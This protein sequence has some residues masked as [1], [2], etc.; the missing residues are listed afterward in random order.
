MRNRVVVLVL[1]IG[2]TFGVDL[3][4]WLKTLNWTEW[5]YKELSFFAAALVAT[6]AVQ[7]QS[8]RSGASVLKDA[9]R[10]RLDPTNPAHLHGREDDVRKFT[11]ALDRG[12]V[13]LVGESG[14][15]KSVTA[16]SIMRLIPDPP[17]KTVGGQVLFEGKDLLKLS[18]EE[19]RSIRGNKISM[20]FQEPGTSLNPVFT[21][22]EQI[23]ESI[24]LHQGKSPS[25]AKAEA[26]RHLDR[27]GPRPPRRVSGWKK[28][29]RR[30][31]GLPRAW[32]ARPTSSGWGASGSSRWG[33]RSA[34][35]SMRPAAG[36]PAPC[37]GARRG[38]TTPAS[39]GSSARDRAG[40][41]CRPPAAGRRRRRAVVACKACDGR[42]RHGRRRDG[43]ER[44]ER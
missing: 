17:G 4:G 41:A 37:P 2:T 39:H 25:E 36:R 8:S 3:A 42:R 27:G 34:R 14:S 18:E 22:G 33:C 29:R 5:T 20:I 15:G 40:T 23:A 26:L 38:T 31:R 16:L 43:A 32:R 44:A 28:S 19:M 1:A 30:P 13:F 11:L 7:W 10:L 12:L 35:P 9:N 6:V 21:V 24:R